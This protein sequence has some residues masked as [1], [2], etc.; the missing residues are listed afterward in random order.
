MISKSKDQLSAIDNLIGIV[1]RMLLVDLLPFDFEDH[2]IGQCVA[3]QNVT[4]RGGICD[5][6]SIKKINGITTD[7][8]YIILQ[9]L[10]TIL[11]RTATEILGESISDTVYEFDN[12]TTLQHFLSAVVHN[13]LATSLHKES[14]TS[15][16]KLSDNLREYYSLE[17]NLTSILGLK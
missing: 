9:A 12:P 2:G 1:T 3:P 8:T 4:M 7:R 11:T 15:S 6:G 5:L 10:G 13:K 14:K 16:K 17:N